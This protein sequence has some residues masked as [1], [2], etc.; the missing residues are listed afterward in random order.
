[1]TSVIKISEWDVPMENGR[2]CTCQ[3]PQRRKKGLVP[4]RNRVLRR[5]IW[6]WE[7]YD[8]SNTYSRL[9]H[10]NGDWEE[11]NRQELKREKELANST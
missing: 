3:G 11:L 1:M 10:P 7:V 5:R 2:D 4:F 8:F 6:L 9:R